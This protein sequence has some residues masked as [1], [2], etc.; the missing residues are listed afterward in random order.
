MRT[1]SVRYR[2]RYR[3]RYDTETN[4]T[5]YKKEGV[6]WRG[7]RRILDLGIIGSFVLIL[8][9]NSDRARHTS[10]GPIVGSF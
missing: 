3:D 7:R 8:L 10:L 6:K 9:A 1:A 2:D 5:K 4:K